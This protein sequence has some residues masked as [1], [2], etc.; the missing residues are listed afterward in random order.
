MLSFWLELTG[1][2]LHQWLGVAIGA[3]AGY[4]LLTHWTWVTAVTDRFFKQTSRQ[5]RLYYLIDATVLIGLATIIVTGL[6]IST[7]FDLA[8]DELRAVEDRL[9][10]IA[11]IGTLAAVV[12]KLGLHWRWIVATARRYIFPQ[13]QQ[14]APAATGMGRREFLR[15]MGSVSVFAALAAGSAVDALAQTASTASAGCA[16]D[17]KQDDDPIH[18]NGQRTS[19]KAPAPARCAAL[20]AARIPAAAGATPTATTTAA[21]IWANAFNYYS[22]A[23]DEICTRGCY[24]KRQKRMITSRRGGTC[25]NLNRLWLSRPGSTLRYYRPSAD[26]HSLR[27]RQRRRDRLEKRTSPFSSRQA[28]HAAGKSSSYLS[29]AYRISTESAHRKVIL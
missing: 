12:I 24:S 26:Q 11:S 19:R 5:A 3:V 28:H 4:H 9:H 14:P 10:V 8:L 6:V 1:V 29:F 7:W 25:F 2:A 13:P 18:R 27:R 16:V 17:T 15:L 22:F 20:T 23:L 21:A